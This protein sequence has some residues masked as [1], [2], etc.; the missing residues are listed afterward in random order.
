MPTN[1]ELPDPE[2]GEFRPVVHYYVTD[3]ARM[4]H[5]NRDWIRHQCEVGVFPNLHIGARYYFT[6][7]H[8]ARIY[9][10][11]TWDGL[12]V[13]TDELDPPPP[14]R[15]GVVVDDPDDIEGVR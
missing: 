14:G 2:T 11:M 13:V 12:A 6:A 8:V 5:T 1:F 9:D 4:L 15:L 7:A 3:V 10:L